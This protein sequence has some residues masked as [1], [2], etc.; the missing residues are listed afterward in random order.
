[1]STDEIPHH[2]PTASLNAA[3]KQINA[4]LRL[5]QAELQ[6]S[7]ELHRLI[8]ESATDYAIFSMDPSGKVISWNEGARRILGW[9]ESE[10]L[11]QA[12]SIIFTPED[13]AAAAPDHEMD[14][15]LECGQAADERWHVRK[16]GSRFWA[17]GQMMPLRDGEVRGFLKILR[18]RTEERRSQEEAR[19][20]EARASDLLEAMGEAFVAMDRNF[21]ILQVNSRATELDGRSREDLLGRVHWE[22]WPASIG[23]PLEAAYRRCMAERVPITLEHHHVSGQR[24]VWFETRAYPTA[25][26]IA[27]FY[28]DINDRKHDEHVL[29]MRARRLEI[30]SETAARLLSARDP[31]DV[32]TPLFQSLS[33]EFGIDASFSYVMDEAGGALRL[34]ACF[35]LSPDAETAVARL[36]M[37]GSSVCSHVAQTRQ[38]LHINDVQATDHPRLS[39]IRRQ[40]FRAYVAFPLL[41]AERLLGTLS[42][43]TRSRDRFSEA[44]LAF[45]GTLTQQVAAVRERLR[46][47]TE[48]RQQ[49]DLLAAITEY[50]AE[51][52][53]LM[54]HEGRITFANPAAEAMFGWQRGELLGHVL[55]DL[56]HH[57]HEDGNFFPAVECPLVQAL[58]SGEVLRGHEDV[59]FCKSGETVDVACSNAPIVAEDKVTGAVLVVHD[60]TERKRAVRA[61]AAS[62]ARLRESEGRFRLLAASSPAIVWLGHRDGTLSY[63][64]DAWYEYTGL[65]AEESLPLGWERILHP[66]DAGTLL[67]AWEKARSEG[68]IYA[69][70]C[71]FR[72]HDGTYRWFQIR[73]TPVRDTGGEVTAWLGNNTDIHDRRT[74][75]DS[76]LDLNEV[77]EARVAE[78]TADRDRMWR[79]STDI[80]LLARFDASITAVNPA[81]QTLLGWSET[82]LLGTHFLDLV[83][84][85]DREATLAAVGRLAEGLRV[86]RFENRYRHKDGSDRWISWTAVPDENFIH[87]VGRD[88]T[89]EKAAAE[90]LE[91]AQEQLRQ[92]HKME[93]VGQLTGGLAHDFNNLLTGITGSLDLLE[94]RIAQRQTQDLSRYLEAAR[95]S[96]QRAATLT[97]RLLAF[98]R[99]QTLDP[100]PTDV[101]KL[102]A[103]MEDLIRRSVGPAIQVEAA[104][105]M[106]LWTTLCDP[107]QLENALLN[108]ALNSRDAMPGG[109]RLTIEA[110]NKSLGDPGAARLRGLDPGEYVMVSVTDTGTGMPPEVAERAFEP[111]YTTKPLG[112]GTGLGLS[113]VYGFAQQSGGRVRIASQ[114]GR[115]T[116]V[117]IYLPRYVGEVPA[118]VNTETPAEALG[119]RTGEVV[120]VVDDEP[121]IR[122]LVTEVLEELGYAAIEAADGP[123]GLRV[124]QSNRR[125]DL[126]VTDVGLPGG[127]NGRQLADAARQQRP[128]LKVLFITGYAE[129]AVIGKTIL[130][131]G[132]QV[133][134]KPFAMQA[135]ATHIRDMIEED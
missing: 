21:R 38:S 9:E 76:L 66:E 68:S 28:R 114:V 13:R 70:D 78:R 5:S 37:D 84:P 52:L 40:G 39:I 56:L 35:G 14:T 88:I 85:E 124:L 4:K 133:V 80:M 1:V 34:A 3:L 129:N 104:I 31:D 11:G 125:V 116:G 22:L 7:F 55:H 115:G 6:R 61:L 48:L 15:A 72:R 98:S 92:S 94:L 25:D 64:N 79:L 126:L 32:L 69:V 2:A 47:E 53:F 122:M 63:L 16:D 112:Q 93:A 24:G 60:I 36:N 20:A 83:H 110:V 119:A 101:A 131:P 51:A 58:S 27:V 127:M 108:L 90:E 73:G 29:R 107:N 100:K 132:M 89:A 128:G 97:H 30:V 82:D 46:S 43:G 19:Q 33:E 118:D 18:D 91:R 41:A 65:T 57:H 117:H 26:G 44:D 17:R 87:A 59:F 77:L 86:L 75:E 111:F 130:E 123:E 109:G 50:A 42:F 74:L 102:V 81:W 10:I 8:L 12:G 71:R 49:T 135:L 120:L 99:R 134:T 113:M 54:D 62:E 45:F 105:P 106:D 67:T 121:V 96:A 103:S 95:S 23:T